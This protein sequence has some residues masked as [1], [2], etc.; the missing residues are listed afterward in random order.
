MVDALLFSVMNGACYFT[1]PNCGQIP[2][3]LELVFLLQFKEFELNWAA[4][5]FFKIGSRNLTSIFTSIFFSIFSIAFFFLNVFSIHLLS[6]QGIFCLVNEI[7]CI[8][9]G[10]VLLCFLFIVLTPLVGGGTIYSNG[11]FHSDSFFRSIYLS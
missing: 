10:F 4:V 8:F 1:E 2:V 7:I 11:F 9:S 3:E 5:F 6:N